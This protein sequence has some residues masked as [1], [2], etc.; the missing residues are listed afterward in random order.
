MK[1][2]SISKALV[3]KI[4]SDTEEFLEQIA[5][6]E[7]VEG[8]LFALRELKEA[9]ERIQPRTGR[10]LR[11]RPVPQVWSL[12]MAD[13]SVCGKITYMGNYCMECGAKMERE[14]E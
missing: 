2:D 1:D 6:S 3:L 7:R 13:C 14:D 10:W 12:F 4:I 11:P 8:Q 5:M 9:V